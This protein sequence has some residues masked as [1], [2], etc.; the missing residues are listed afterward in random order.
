MIRLVAVN[1]GDT[2]ARLTQFGVVT[3]VVPLSRHPPNDP[4]S[5][6]VPLLL[7][8]DLVS[9]QTV[10]TEAFGAGTVT[11]SE[12]GDIQRNQMRLYCFGYFDYTDTSHPPVPRKTS[13]CRI[14]S[15]SG[16]EPHAVIRG[17][18]IKTV[19][20]EQSEHNYAD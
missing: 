17:A 18:F 3:H 7:A 20:S 2:T 16:T 10:A 19:D 8:T 15:A 11:L 9:G 13:F 5:E 6:S 14:F 12:L 1:T 4:F